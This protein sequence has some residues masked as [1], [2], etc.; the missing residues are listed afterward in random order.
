M[1]FNERFT[2]NNADMNFCKNSIAK[3][4]EINLKPLLDF[5]E[6]NMSSRGSLQIKVVTFVN[7]Y[8]FSIFLLK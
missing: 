5:Y 4:N 2:L 3:Y 8:V 6:N 7:Q 1:T